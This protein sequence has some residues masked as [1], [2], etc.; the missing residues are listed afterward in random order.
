MLEGICGW[1]ICAALIVLFFHFSDT[2][3]DDG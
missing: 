2:G 1:M 3:E